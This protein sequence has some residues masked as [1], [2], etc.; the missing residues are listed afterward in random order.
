MARRET[1]LEYAAIDN[2][3]TAIL[4]PA[5]LQVG[6]IIDIAYSLKR[7][8]PVLAATSET[9]LDGWGNLPV[10][11]VHVQAQ[12]PRSEKVTWRASDGVSA[13]ESRS[14][15]NTI[16]DLLL[17][18][19]QPVVQPKGAPARFIV[20]PRIEL[21]SYRSWSEV[22]KRFAPLYDKSSMPSG[23]SPLLDQIA[24]IRAVSDDPKQRAALALSLV[25][26][27]VRYVFL[28]MNDGGL[29]PADADLT[30]SRRFGDCK[31]KTVLLLALLHGLGITAAC[32]RV[33]E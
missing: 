27:Q 7:A 2:T 3:L 22:S 20:D 1:N 23:R 12:W 21:T 14:G 13:Q 26:N 15:E 11:R 4:Q 6:D 8:D 33:L 10:S 28:G 25:E 24:K 19:V 31:A 18:D 5:G 17:N 30:W 29:V 16:V 9:L 32:L